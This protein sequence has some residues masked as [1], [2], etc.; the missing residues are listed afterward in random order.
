MNIRLK[1]ASLVFLLSQSLSI[2]AGQPYYLWCS[3]INV[4]DEAALFSPVKMI[5]RYSEMDHQE[6]VA[7]YAD[8]AK[9]PGRTACY[10]G[11]DREEV[12]AGRDKG[13]RFLEKQGWTH[14]VTSERQGFFDFVKQYR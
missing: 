1:V 9:W 7:A 4:E 13:K 14:I 2:Y 10:G 5:T 6:L 3:H 11:S 12:E 8:D